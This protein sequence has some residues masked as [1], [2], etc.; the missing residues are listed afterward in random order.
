VLSQVIL[1]D[2][3]A[4]RALVAKVRSGV[5]FVQAA[6][7]AG[8]S[9]ADISLGEQSRE[10]FAKLASPAAATAAFAVP[11]GG[12][13]DPVKSEL[14]WHVVHVNEVKGE[15][16]RPLA[17]V[18]AEI[19]AS[20]QKQKSD[21]ALA[22]MV[23]AI[24]DAIGDGSSFD[25]VV[26]SEKLTVVTTPPVLPNGSAPDT[27]G[28]APPAELPRL[29]RTGFELAADD[30]PTVETIG[31]GNSYALLDVSQVLPSAP[32]PLAKIRDQVMRDLITQRAADRAKAVA[33][34]IVAK[35][36]A[37][38]PLAQ[39]F[40]EAGVRLPPLQQAGGRQIDLAQANRPVPP[41]LAR[42]FQ[43]QRGKTQLLPAPGNEGWFVV[44][45]Q[46]V[47]PGDVKSAPGL[48]QATRAEFSGVAAAEYAEQ[49]TNAVRKDI[50]VE[51]NPAAIA[52]LKKRLAGNQ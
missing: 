24:E 45:L 51:K 27:P 52:R 15:A 6:A 5:A 31:A 38:T 41:P 39:A 26:K 18:R 36:N 29:L 44:Q 8:F 12:T 40:A 19:A 35:A 16:A 34:A 49:F 17:A 21:E 23:T 10:A 42:L 7:Q 14:G 4:A 3:A 32:V 2:Q 28:W 20:L 30:D 33:S 25:D 13:T 47:I 46:S 9:A 50:G 11:Q 1:P 48:V 43:M 37:G 22:D